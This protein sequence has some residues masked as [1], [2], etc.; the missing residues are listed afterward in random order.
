[1]QIYNAI[2]VP[3]NLL[4]LENALH[5]RR[6]KKPLEKKIPRVQNLEHR[7]NSYTMKRVDQAAIKVHN[8]Q[9]NSP[10]STSTAITFRALTRVTLLVLVFCL[11]M[12]WRALLQPVSSFTRTT[13]PN[14]IPTPNSYL[15][16]PL[17]WFLN[18]CILLTLV[19]G[20]I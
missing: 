16:T 20:L 12:F 2:T 7:S 11:S 6:E 8:C 14:E 19:C 1:M 18:C 17:A 5:I 3:I 10:H 9:P 15:L 13:T 4:F